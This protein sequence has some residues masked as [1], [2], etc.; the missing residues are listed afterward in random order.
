MRSIAYCLIVVCGILGFGLNVTAAPAPSDAE[1]CSATDITS[2]S[3]TLNGKA[4]DSF[5][6]PSSPMI[7]W[8]QYG[9]AS[10]LNSG[11]S[12]TQNVT[13]GVVTEISVGVS[14]LSPHTSY[15]Y[16]IA[17]QSQYELLYGRERSFVTLP[18]TSTTTE[19]T[20]MI[21]ST[22]GSGCHSAS[23]KIT[24]AITG[25]GIE[26]AIVLGG[27]G[28][29]STD[30]SGFYSWS[31][32]EEIMCCGGSYT[33]TASADGYV[34]QSQSIEIDPQQE[35]TLN[36]ELQPI[37]EAEKITIFPHIL[38]LKSGQSSEITVLLEGDS[39]VSEGKTVTAT[40]GKAGKRRISISSA[41][42]V[43]DANGEAKF[44]IA[45]KDKIGKARIIFETGNLK[46]TI[47]VKI[48]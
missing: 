7:V 9:T 11:T 16:R 32:P 1:T 23:G 3:A 12:T 28:M 40:I 43:T 21:S 45:A 14:G 5:S 44:T 37:C 42:E 46:K 19:T 24:D 31:D 25:E 38:K 20:P 27:L 8:F 4:Y 13:S 22:S 10:G 17:A 35:G 34:S 18:T 39:C 6:S 30:A 48:K 15:Y 47:L 26:S 33:L 36:F 29:S 2:D 41:S